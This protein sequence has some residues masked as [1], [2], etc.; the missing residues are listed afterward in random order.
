M[1][2]LPSEIECVLH[3][4]I[5]ALTSFRRMGMACITRGEYAWIAV[6]S[7]GHVIKAVGDAVANVVDRPPDHFFHI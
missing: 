1:H 6:Y 7:L 4:H 2:Q 5:H 3:R